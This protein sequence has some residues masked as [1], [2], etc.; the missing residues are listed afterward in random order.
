MSEKN[1]QKNKNEKTKFID[2]N[3]RVFGVISAIDLLVILAVIV[4]CVGVYLKNNV[5]TAT[6]ASVDNVTISMTLEVRI[7]EEYIADAFV[8]GDPMYDRENPSG[9]PIGYITNIEYTEP[10]AIREL[11]DGTIDMVGSDRD[12]N[13]LVTLEGKGSYQD[14][15]YIFNR[16]YEMGMNAAR[17]FQTKY[18]RV[19]GFV[20]DIHVVE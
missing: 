1:K 4:V 6:N 2:K 7:V 19:S 10:R 16:I 13:M 11:I 18:S 12:I 14:G 8:V 3:G 9:G 5:L 20:V 17:T 15:H